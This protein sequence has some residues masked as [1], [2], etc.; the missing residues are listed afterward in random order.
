M[1]GIM[2]AFL[3]FSYYLVLTGLHSFSEEKLNVSI[4]RPFPMGLMSKTRDT[5]DAKC[6]EATLQEKKNRFSKNYQLFTFE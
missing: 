6:I 2:I 1:N 5:G 4:N 3:Q